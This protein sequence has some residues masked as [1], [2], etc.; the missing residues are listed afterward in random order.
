VETQVGENFEDIDESLEHVLDR[1]AELESQV[2]AN[3]E[4]Y[5]EDLEPIRTQLETRDQLVD[6]KE[7][8][9][10]EG[11]SSAVCD[12]CGCTV[13]LG[14]LEKPHC[15][16]CTRKFSGLTDGGWVPFSKPRLQTDSMRRTA[17]DMTV[18]GV[19]PV[20]SDRGTR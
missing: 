12:T 8:A 17:D 15:P 14:L 7:T 2:S 6:L 13:N 20:E 16:D 5:R 10:R 9:L 18:E 1:L 4:A 11:I 19:P 3:A